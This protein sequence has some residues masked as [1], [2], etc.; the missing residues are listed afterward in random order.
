MGVR[1]D[2]SH[3]ALQKIFLMAQLV[4]LV[5]LAMPVGDEAT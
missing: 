2:H 3:L 4:T 1:L 5:Y